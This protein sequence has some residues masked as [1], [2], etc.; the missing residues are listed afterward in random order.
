[1]LHFY[2]YPHDTENGNPSDFLIQQM[3]KRIQGPIPNNEVLTWGL[4]AIEGIS[5]AHVITWTIIA[6]FVAVFASI[7]FIYWWLV[8]HPADL[9]NAF[10]PLFT[11]FAA[12]SVVFGAVQLVLAAKELDKQKSE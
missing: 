12:M 8:H 10:I 6:F 3:P 2:N 1:M 9:Q 5:C 4:I 7:I 11:L